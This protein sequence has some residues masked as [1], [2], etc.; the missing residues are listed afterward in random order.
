MQRALTPAS[1]CTVPSLEMAVTVEAVSEG[2]E[3]GV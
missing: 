3:G 2:D 1:Q